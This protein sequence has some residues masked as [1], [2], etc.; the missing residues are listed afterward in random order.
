[1]TKINEYGR[2]WPHAVGVD[3]QLALI[4]WGQNGDIARRLVRDGR[5]M[6]LLVLLRA[7]AT[8]RRL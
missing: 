5:S 3:R 1:M 2:H 6:I 4:N 8:G 7:H